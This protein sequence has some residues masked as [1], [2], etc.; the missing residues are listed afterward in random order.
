MA[1]SVRARKAADLTP[2]RPADGVEGLDVREAAFL[3]GC[4]PH[5][6]RHAIARGDLPAARLGRRVLVP[7]AAVER[8]L[9]GVPAA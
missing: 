7:R 4:H 8:L 6:V 1:T 2:R 5:T 9:A 3:L